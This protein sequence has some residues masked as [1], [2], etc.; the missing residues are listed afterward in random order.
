[1]R[2]NNR[3]LI[4]RYLAVIFVLT[5]Y[6]LLSIKECDAYWMHDAAIAITKQ[7]MLTDTSYLFLLPILIIIVQ[8]FFNIKTQVR[9][10]LIHLFSALASIL[11]LIFAINKPCENLNNDHYM[12]ISATMVLGYYLFKFVSFIIIGIIIVHTILSRNKA[13]KAEQV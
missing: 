1:M 12:F 3:Q 11:L 7:K 6:T 8:M 4:F 2:I 9:L 13:V 5:I 10:F